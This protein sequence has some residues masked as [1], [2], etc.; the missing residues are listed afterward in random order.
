MNTITSS[1]VILRKL[2]DDLIL[3][4]STPADADALAEFNSKIHSDF[5]PDTP[6]ERIGA[7]VRDLLTRPHPSFDPADFTIVEDTR[8]GKI[9]SS[10]NL[11][12]QTWAYAGIPFGVARI[13]VVG[14]HPDYRRRGLVRAQFDEVHTW[15][16]ARGHRMQII[17]GI[18]NYYRQFGYEMG[19]DLGGGRVG[20]E[21]QLPSLKEGESERF[22]LRPALESD[23]PFIVQ[24]NHHADRRS[25]VTCPRDENIWRYELLGVSPQNVNRCEVRIIENSSGESLGYLTH[26]WYNWDNG[27]SLFSYELKPGVAW[28]DV[29]PAVARYAWKTGQEYAANSGKPVHSFGFWFGL[30]HPSYEVLREGLPRVRDPYAFYLR[31]PDL[32]AFLCL[33]APALEARLAASELAIGHSGKLRLNFYRSGLELE[34]ASGRLAGVQAY[35]PASNQDG[36]AAFPDLTFLQLLFGYRSFDELQLSFA[37]SWDKNEEARVLINVLFPKQPSKVQPVA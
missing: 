23:I 10:L 8:T 4:R 31:L 5:G 7:W 18:P 21:S 25:L 1:S 3:R 32:P 26:P 22:H 13:E 17:T 34:F 36:D 30:S 20:S 37:D 16:Q 24:V 28:M 9:V 33:I 15:S 19:L 35:D 2:G 12:P 27:V 6:D 29:T 11:I 14:T